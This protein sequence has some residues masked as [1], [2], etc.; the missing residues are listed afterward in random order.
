MVPGAVYRMASPTGYDS[1]VV[2]RSAGYALAVSVSLCAA[3][4]LSPAPLAQSSAPHPRKV[5][6]VGLDAADWIAIDPLIR[7]GR[8]PAFARLRSAGRT[9][10]MLSTPPL[11]SPMIWTTIATGVEPENHGILDFM[12]DLADGHQAPVG[13]SQ[14]LAPALWNLF[15]AAGKKVAVAGWWAT[16]PAEQVRGTIVSDAL[17]PQLTR[18]HP[19]VGGGIVSPSSETSHMLDLVVR[20]ASMSRE[21]LSRYVPITGDEHASL[22]RAFAQPDGL[23]YKDPLAHL[24]AVAAA[25]V[26][27]SRI[28]ERLASAER[29]DLLA[30]YLEGIDTVSHLFVRDRVRGPAAIARAYQDADALIAALASASPPDALVIV[31]SDHG[32]YP[33]AAAIEED[34][35]NLTGPA[36]AWHRPYGMVA[37]ATAGAL[38]RGTADSDFPG[39]RDIGIVTPLDIAPTV[40]HAAGLRIPSD[41][42]GRV[43]DAMLP[44]DAASRSVQRMAPV[45]YTPPPLPRSD[46]A[47]DKEALARL[48]ALGYVGTVKT[49]L[50]RRNL[51]ESYFRRRKLPEAERELRAVLQTQPS[52]LSAALWLAQVLQGEGRAR[53]ALE[54]YARA[55]R[56][57]GGA[58]EALVQAVD[59]AIAQSD[60]EQAR[61]FVAASARDR[62]ATVAALISQAAIAEAEHDVPRA[63]RGYR[64]V[65]STDPLSFD[66]AARLLDLVRASG[67]PKDALAPIVRATGLAP[68]S[69]RHLA[70]LGEARLASGDG[71]GAESALRRAVAL[72]PDGQMARVALGRALMVQSKAADAIAVLLP[73][74]AMAERDVLL[75]AAYSST[76]DWPRAIQHLQAAI[77]EGRSGPDVLNGLGW[78][79]MQA[80]HRDRAAGWFAR[81]LAARPDQPEIR[82]LL[83]QLHRERSQ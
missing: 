52:D 24:A 31:C 55:L 6:I 64:L 69:A 56:L 15:S 68:D 75:G 51:G 71:S 41:M 33:A 37:V 20:P 26:T 60:L 45:A 67:R 57:P 27:Y 50:A 46:L 30:V 4:A 65:L 77:D 13:S 16:W 34:P 43:I 58:R 32:F 17:A 79:E 1:S 25:T 39:A 23:F 62:S 36:T 80:G 7:A 49:S 53:E 9:G 35:S 3:L 47:G 22:L 74:P 54:V 48:Q 44:A 78:A 8:L 18:Q 63:E 29:P 83:D 81:S 42:P 82:T 73:L 61:G 10:I 2:R 76:R 70:L 28:A 14:R 19:A 72:A 5:V 66:A 59:L 11:V 12:V 38:A 40:L 21:A